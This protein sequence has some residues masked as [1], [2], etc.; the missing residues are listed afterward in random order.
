MQ[1]VILV[2]HPHSPA[3]SWRQEIRRR[4]T[5]STQEHI[6]GSIHEAAY[7]EQFCSVALPEYTAIVLVQGVGDQYQDYPTIATIVTRARALNIPVHNFLEVIADFS[8]VAN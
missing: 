3:R 1:S 7:T 8:P 5:T 2:I 4:F 6:N